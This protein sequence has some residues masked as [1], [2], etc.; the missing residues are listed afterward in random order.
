LLSQWVRNLPKWDV[1]YDRRVRCCRRIAAIAALSAL[2]LT[3]VGASDAPAAG[4]RIAGWGVASAEEPNHVMAISIDTV[5]ASLGDPTQGW[6]GP[7]GGQQGRVHVCTPWNCV[8][9][10]LM[11]SPKPFPI[12]DL[13]CS[14]IVSYGNTTST[15]YGAVYRTG[16]QPGWYLFRVEDRGL[17]GID[18]LGMTYQPGERDIDDGACGAA[19]V[20]VAPLLAG[21][22]TVASI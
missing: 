3:L 20:P 4:P 10:A 11:G 16:S 6:F 21:D 9:T 15:W 7:P 12:M 17:A 8:W 1:P 19:D 2:C 13:D 14:R 18:L 22:F 5:G